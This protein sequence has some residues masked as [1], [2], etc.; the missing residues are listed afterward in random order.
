[1]LEHLGLAH[2]AAR[3]QQQRGPEEF[4]DLLQESRVGLIRGLDRFETQRGLRP[5]SYLL[6]RATGQIL[7]Y[8]R[9][10]FRTIRIPWRLRDLYA[11]GLK[12]QRE[13]EQHRQPALGDHEL[14][15]ALSV[16][17]ER[18]AAAVR[19][20]GAGQVLELSANPVEPTNSCEDDEQLNWLRSVL[21]QVEGMPGKVLQAHLIEGQSIKSLTEAFNCSRSSLRLH[22]NEGLGLL[23]EWAHR[24]GLMPLPPN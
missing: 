8:R 20:H 12:I 19:S 10:R 4:E 23:R 18:W 6:S 22:L 2:C 13:R 5:S 9:D 11:A 1:M 3:R 17:P 15:A 21:H 24:D 16:R 14:A 7:H